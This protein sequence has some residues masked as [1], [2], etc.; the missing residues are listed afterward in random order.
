M[1]APTHFEV[2]PEDG[3]AY[4]VIPANDLFPDTLIQV[5]LDS[6]GAPLFEASDDDTFFGGGEVDWARGFEDDADR[7]RV[8]AIF[9]RLRAGV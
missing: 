5:P 8:Q 6:E 9:E 1:N 2:S 7:D 3:S 4:Y